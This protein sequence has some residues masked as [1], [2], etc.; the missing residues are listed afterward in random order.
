[1]VKKNIKNSS[2][3]YQSD[4]LIEVPSS[5]DL[6][7]YEPDDEQ[8]SLENKSNDEDRLQ[9]RD[10]VNE[11][12][13]EIL[14]K[15]VDELIAE[16]NQKELD[17]YMAERERKIKEVRSWR[18]VDEVL[19]LFHWS[20]AKW[21]IAGVKYRFLTMNENKS[22]SELIGSIW[23][24][25][26]TR[27]IKAIRSFPTNDTLYDPVQ[28]EAYFCIEK[29][30]GHQYII[31]YDVKNYKN[32]LG[33][34][35]CSKELYALPKI[36]IQNSTTLNECIYTIG[37]GTLLTLPFILILALNNSF[38]NSIKEILY[39]LEVIGIILV[40]FQLWKTYVFEKIQYKFL[41]LKELSFRQFFKYICKYS[42]CFCG[43]LFTCVGISIGILM[44]L[45][46]SNGDFYVG[47][48]NDT[49]IQ[50]LLLLIGLFYFG[51]NI[52]ISDGIDYLMIID[53]AKYN[54]QKKFIFKYI[55]IMITG[56]I[57]SVLWIV[58]TIYYCPG[59]IQAINSISLLPEINGI[60]FL[61]DVFQDLIIA[62]YCCVMPYL[63]SGFIVF[64]IQKIRHA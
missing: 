16:A 60:D 41:F 56:L 34:V 49:I 17:D 42:Y 19:F 6:I 53:H 50:L 48:N 51:L 1:M 37:I 27:D 33:A 63:V 40:F 64:L 23:E 45:V 39:G 7:E 29:K 61:N 57:L 20:P 4:D 9:G 31:G 14:A 2:E 38:I 10:Y 36:A 52:G 43:L 59:L 15:S 32:K 25:I 44:I 47:L 3:S 62:I 21:I 58:F 54:E 5:D 18:H 28:T 46:L 26:R 55:F 11:V 22:D 12:I 8:A 30:N 24:S 35:K 13:E